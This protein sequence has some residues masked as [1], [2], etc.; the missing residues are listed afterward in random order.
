MC[1]PAPHRLSL[2]LS[3]QDDQ[4]LTHLTHTHTHTPEHRQL[5]QHRPTTMAVWD[6][7][8]LLV[9]LLV[10][11]HTRGAWATVEVNMED[12]VE[13][14]RGDTARLTCMFKSDDGIGGIT[15]IWFCVTRSDERQKIYFQDS[16][17]KIVDRGT[18]FT[19]RISVNGTGA[20][21]EVVLTINDVRLAD[22][23]EFI[24]FIKSLTVGSA[25]GRTKLRVFE[26]PNRPT[27]EAVQT[28]VSVNQQS[29][30]KIGVCEVKNGFPKPNITWYRDNTPLRDV[31]DEVK[32]VPSITSESSGL[33]SVKSEL[34]LKVTKE[35]K[36]AEFYCEV[37]YLVPGGT[38]MTETDRINITVYYPPTAVN[39]W[40]Q[41]P[42]GKIK[43]GDSIELHCHGN[44]NT[45]SSELTISKGDV[46]H[47]LEANMLVLH[48]VTRLNSGN[49]RCTS[50]DMDT[51]EGIS[52]NTTVFVHYLN[53]A[54]VIPEDPV[55]VAQGQ[56][57][58]AT[59]NALS[60][61]Q[62]N[63]AWFKDGELV[64]RSH[65]LILRDATYDSAG[66]YV[67]VVTV[68]EIEGMETSGTL[69]VDVWGPPEITRPDDT[70]IEASFESSVD[71]RCLA[72]GFPSPNITWNTSDGKVLKTTSEKETEAGVQSVVSVYVTS[73]IT[74]FCN[75]SSENGTDSVTFN[76]KATIHTTTQVTTTQAIATSSTSLSSATVKAASAIPPKKSKKAPSF[77]QTLPLSP[78][79]QNIKSIIHTSSCACCHAVVQ[80]HLS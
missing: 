14:F 32:V 27:I 74:A 40:V 12:R 34:S 54:V 55:Q 4:L 43:E 45:P 68:P 28:G 62:T 7:A 25:E 15:I 23:L 16:T 76:I 3:L 33:F 22:E 67:C 36:D 64:S 49:Y 59:C 30:S 50:L 46:E 10:L 17:M 13:V 26:T 78:D 56:E 75:A 18:Q 11:L 58:M 61:L 29:L 57:L 70:E 38:R 47:T 2:S 63:T 6:T 66:T 35:D 9:G 51:F 79:E 53:H 71:L 69:H 5:L 37:N 8:S 52:G 24:C 44:G 48:N 31:Q 72:R 21:G 60:S 1:L 73:D 42:V 19:D 80:A 65:T 39:V 20:N 41:S 77:R